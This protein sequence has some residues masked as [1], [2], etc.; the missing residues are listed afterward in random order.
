M[1]ANVAVNAQ[2][3]KIT[4]CH[5]ISCSLCSAVIVPTIHLHYTCKSTTLWHSD[6]VVV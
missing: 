4:M 5:A 1:W 2:S 6:S 3:I